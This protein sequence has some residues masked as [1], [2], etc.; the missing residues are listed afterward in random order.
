[1]FEGHI[2]RTE[3]LKRIHENWNPEVMRSETVKVSDAAGR[4]LAEDQFSK[5][6]FPVYRASAMDGI[7]VNFDILEDGMPDTSAWRKGIEYIRADTGDDFDDRYDTV[8]PVE[9]VKWGSD[10]RITVDFKENIKRGNSVHGAGSRLKK[11]EIL[12]NKGTEL[13]AFH[14]ARLVSG[15]ITKVPVI[16]K[17]VVAFLPTGSELIRAGMVPERG[18]NID[19]NSIMAEYE[20][21]AAGAEPLMYSITQDKKDEL[22]QKLN[23]AVSKADIVIINGGSSKGEED[24]NTELLEKNGELLFHW[25]RSAP[26]RPVSAAVIKNKLV[27]NLA[28]PS[29]A[30]LAGF[31]WL[32]GPMVQRLTGRRSRIFEYRDAVLDKDMKSPPLDL[33]KLMRAYEKGGVIYVTDIERGSSESSG[34]NAYFITDYNKDSYKRGEHILIGLL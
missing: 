4:L 8:I 2:I 12:V 30:A 17:P 28:G 33:F 19:S 11:G 26:G 23:D 10:G 6:D 29:T 3:A 27:V 24:F 14:L 25:V 15:G 31:K 32:I 21:K 9:W 18:Q 16:K 20:I 7:A 13:K 22:E 1:M 5:Y 34:A